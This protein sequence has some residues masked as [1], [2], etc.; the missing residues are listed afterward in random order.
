MIFTLDDWNGLITDIN[1]LAVDPPAGCSAVAT[2]PLAV[3]PHIFKKTDITSARATLL[4]LCYENAFPSPLVIWLQDNIDEIE[5]AIATG[6]CNC[7][8]DNCDA[9]Y[10][11]ICA[12]SDL[13]SLDRERFPDISCT[14]PENEAG[15]HKISGHRHWTVTWHEATEVTR[16]EFADEDCEGTG[17]FGTLPF[18][19]GIVDDD[20][21]GSDQ[22]TKIFYTN[23]EA[24]AR[25]VYDV[26]TRALAS[27]CAI[28][29]F[30]WVTPFFAAP[31]I[32]LENTIFPTF[33]DQEYFH[34]SNNCFGSNPFPFSIFD[35]VDC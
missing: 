9:L 31:T 32:A 26:V 16:V 5:A 18:D 24:R 22:R 15:A 8:C 14:N 23:N 1:A 11:G 12:I 17:T 2:L 13:A 28:V 7:D 10:A 33:I 27:P 19:V 6:W 30:P 21:S 4:Q 35:A 25:L 20:N 29:G 34:R 3:D